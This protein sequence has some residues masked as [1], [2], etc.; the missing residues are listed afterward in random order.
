LGYK[1]L[2]HIERTRVLFHLVSAVSENPLDDYENIREELGMYNPTLLEKPEWILV[3]RSDEQDPKEVKK[4]IRS[5]K[6]KN[7]QVLE[8]SILDENSLE[9]IKKQISILEKEYKKIDQTESDTRA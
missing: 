1:F 4:I 3:S 9:V 6:R 7:P 5:L 8:C 2:R